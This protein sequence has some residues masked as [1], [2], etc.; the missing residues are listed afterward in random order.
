MYNHSGREASFS[1]PVYLY[2]EQ[3]LSKLGPVILSTP[4]LTP[5][6]VER[7]TYLIG[8]FRLAWPALSCVSTR[9]GSWQSARA[10]VCPQPHT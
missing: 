1:L 6:Q 4:S 7:V 10:L 5:T 8:D 9:I 3:A 2:A